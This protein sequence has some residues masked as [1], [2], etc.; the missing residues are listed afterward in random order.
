MAKG[1]RKKKQVYGKTTVTAVGKLVFPR[2]DKAEPFQE[3]QEPK[4]S[5]HVVCKTD[6]PKNQELIQDIEAVGL[7]A[8]GE[9]WTTDPNMYRPYMTG[10]K[11]V[12]NI[13]ANGGEP[14]ENTIALYDG[15]IRILAKGDGSK[16]PPDCYL[17]DKSKLPRRPGNEDDLKNIRETYYDGAFV[18]LAVTP[19][20]FNTGKNKGV[21][22]IL[23]GVQFVKDGERLRGINLEDAFSSSIEEDDF[24][25]DETAGAFSDDAEEEAAVGDINV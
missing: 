22:L 18:R 23:K 12:E 14:S 2:I 15:H 16:E 10:E 8:F 5:A 24:F 20:S 6:T 9:A 19:Y 7:K 13:K 25:E 3:G 17:A 11:V 4:F 1:S 21:A